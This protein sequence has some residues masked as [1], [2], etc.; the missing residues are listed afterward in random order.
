MI[1][2]NFFNSAF[3]V[4]LLMV[5]PGCVHKIQKKN[6]EKK[7][8]SS[9]NFVTVHP[10][11]IIVGGIECADCAQ[12][13]I[14]IVCN[15]PN[16]KNPTFIGPYEQGVI[17]YYWYN[18]EDVDLKNL[19]ESLSKEGFDLTLLQGPCKVLCR[20]DVDKSKHIVVANTPMKV[21]MD[22]GCTENI[23]EKTWN[24]LSSDPNVRYRITCQKKNNQWIA[25]INTKI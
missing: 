21:F 9:D 15:I 14:S 24:I 8:A 12:S 6:I 18:N 13:V 3:I 11:K 7:Y 5:F 17:S 1:R 10:F 23:D 25:I 20:E 2:Y 16:I 22:D 19:I 4:L